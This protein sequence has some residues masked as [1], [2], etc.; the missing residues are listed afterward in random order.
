[1]FAIGDV[2]AG[3]YQDQVLHPRIAHRFQC[4]RIHRLAHIDAV[5]LRTQGRVPCLDR[6]RHDGA[7]RRK[8]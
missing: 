7:P 5:D 8:A 6:D 1:M 3:K 2:L 4:R